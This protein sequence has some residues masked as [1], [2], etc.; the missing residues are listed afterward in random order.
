M[1]TKQKICILNFPILNVR[2]CIMIEAMEQSL[3]DRYLIP[4][5]THEIKIGFRCIK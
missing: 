1:T 3:E 2:Y 4:E 5:K